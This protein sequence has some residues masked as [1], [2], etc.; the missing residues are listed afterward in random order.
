MFACIEPAGNEN[1]LIKKFINNVKVP[2]LGGWN[3]PLGVGL[4]QLKN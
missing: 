4:D 2:R 1:Y 3:T